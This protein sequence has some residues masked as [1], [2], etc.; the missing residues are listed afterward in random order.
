MFAGMRLLVTDLDGILVF[1]HVVKQA[2]AEA[3]MRWRAA[4]NLLVLT[5]G[6][7]IRLVQHAVEVARAPTPVGLDYDYAVCAIGMTVIDAVGQMHRTRTLEADQVRVV[8]RAISDVTQV[9][10][11]VLAST[12][13]CD[14]VL[15]D[16][17]GLSTDQ[18]TPS[19]RF[20]VTPPSRV[21]GL[22]VTPM[23]LHIPDVRTSV[24]LA[25]DLEETVDGTSCTRSIGFVSVAAAGE[26]EGM[27]LGRL[28]EL[29]ADQGMETSEVV[30]ADDSWNDISMFEQAD[31]LCAMAGAPGKVV[32]AAGGYITPSVAAFV[33]ALPARRCVEVGP[34]CRRRLSPGY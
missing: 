23:S 22:G 30:A 13:G 2:D 6:R 3:L 19:D 9:P 29:L 28:T 33:D 26:S 27:G 8:V 24:A 4:S 25:G 18:R 15:D 17:T 12:L 16:P 11:S 31:V 5:T 1:H 14:H 21:A 34:A 10:T 7:S 32:E 20:T